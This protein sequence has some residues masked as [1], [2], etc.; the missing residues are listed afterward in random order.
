MAF[1]SDRYGHP[2]VYVMNVDG[3]GVHRVTLDGSYN[4]SPAWSP[5]GDLIAYTNRVG[6]KFGIA[7]VDPET[8]RSRQLVGEAGN[9]EDSSWSSD[10]RYISFASDRTGTY[11]IYI[12]DRD[13]RKEWRITSGKGGKNQPAWSS[14]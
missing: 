13:G 14:K 2:Q 4:T 6:G 11:Q 10:G 12:V 7:L 9:N 8:L 5:T 1:V 3:S